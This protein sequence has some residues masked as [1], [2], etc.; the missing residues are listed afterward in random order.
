M[1]NVNDKKLESLQTSL[2]VTGGNIDDHEIAWL[3]SHGATSDQINEAWREVMLLNGASSPN[4]NDAAKEFLDTIGTPYGHITDSWWWF[5]TQIGDIG[6]GI[7]VD[8]LLLETGDNLLLED[9]GD[10]VLVLE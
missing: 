4:V 2:S 8:N 6:A 7:G 3:Q 9:V 10:F 1:P 5:W